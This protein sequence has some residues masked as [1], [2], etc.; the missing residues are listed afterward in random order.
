[1]LERSCGT[2]PYTVKDGTVYYLLIKDKNG[3]ECGFPKGHIEAGETEEETALRE[4][5]EETSVKPMITDG[6]RHEISYRMNNGNDKNV[7]YFLAE[8]KA[9]TPRHNK[10]FENFTYLLL[11]F[12]KAYE[13]L[14]F[15][16]AKQMLKAANDFLM[17]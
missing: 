6:F 3:G 14:T 17:K 1:M 5:W 10:N 8:F 4:T 7:V 13:E 16:S 11:P 15:D 12:E 2:I 9:Q